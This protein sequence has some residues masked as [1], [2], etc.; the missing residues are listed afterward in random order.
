M[1]EHWNVSARQ[2]ELS[3]VGGN[4]HPLRLAVA[5]CIDLRL[6]TESRN[7]RHASHQALRKVAPKRVRQPASRCGYEECCKT[8]QLSA[9][10][11]DMHV[12]W[13]VHPDDQRH[14]DI[15]RTARPGVE[16]HVR[17]QSAASILLNRLLD[18][19]Q[20]PIRRKY[21]YVSRRQ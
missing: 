10:Q 19:L 20:Y 2:W 3:G 18:R 8:P 7:K 14:L 16:T 17:R 9:D 13:T 1:P 15:P 6:L 21:R 5:Y 11:D 4:V 12:S